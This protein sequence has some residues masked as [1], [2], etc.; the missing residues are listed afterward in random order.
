LT[1]FC[2]HTSVN[3]YL[4]KLKLLN[5]RKCWRFEQ[6][7]WAP[8]P[9]LPVGLSG[10]ALESFQLE[11]TREKIVFSFGGFS[12]GSILDSPELK[13]DLQKGKETKGGYSNAI[14]T[15]KEGQSMFMPQKYN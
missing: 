3:T 8:I 15:W 2:N 7:S 13:S 14:L 4:S 12:P 9:D 5:C 6:E 10:S 11:E 1:D